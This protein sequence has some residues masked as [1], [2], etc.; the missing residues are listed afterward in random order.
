MSGKGGRPSLEG[1]V[2]K[3]GE[4]NGRKKRER[5]GNGERERKV[6]HMHERVRTSYKGD[7]VYCA[8]PRS[9]RGCLTWV[10]RGRE[11]TL[12]PDGCRNSL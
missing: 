10:E 12:W 4:E 3:R 8:A 6:E 2:R 7:V 5:G 9:M 1:T 11:S